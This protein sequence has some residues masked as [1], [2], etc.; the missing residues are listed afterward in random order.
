MDTLHTKLSKLTRMRISIYIYTHA[1]LCVAKLKSCSYLQPCVVC[2]W[3]FHILQ[4]GLMLCHLMILNAHFSLLNAWLKINACTEV[5]FRM[6]TLKTAAPSISAMK[7]TLWSGFTAM[8]WNYEMYRNVLVFWWSYLSTTIHD[9]GDYLGRKS[10]CAWSQKKLP[11]CF[12]MQRAVWHS[13]TSFPKNATPPSNTTFVAKYS[14]KAAS[15]RIP[16]S[17]MGFAVHSKKSGCTDSMW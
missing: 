2:Q 12:V 5:L 13:L 3:F 15:L 16:M 10:N 17:L 1:C 4:L 9:A 7:R 14:P 11:P 6:E 8:I